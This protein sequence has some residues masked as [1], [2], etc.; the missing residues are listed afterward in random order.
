MRILFITFALAAL[1]AP[2]L[3]AEYDGPFCVHLPRVFEDGFEIADEKLATGPSAVPDA[4]P[5]WN[6][7]LGW[8]DVMFVPTDLP[9]PRLLRRLF[10]GS[11]SEG[12]PMP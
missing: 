6:R 9:A 7:E 10:I 5:S 4:T 8:V 2:A 11:S 1:A 3:A 12:L